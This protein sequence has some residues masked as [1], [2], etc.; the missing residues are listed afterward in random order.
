MKLSPMPI[1][2]RSGLFLFLACALSVYSQNAVTIRIDAARSLGPVGSPWAYVGYDEPNYT[3]SANG[4]KL[5]H[6]L[7]GST[8]APFQFRA[9]NLLTT[10]DATPGLKFGSTDA[11]TENA[12]GLPVYNWKVVDQIFDTYLAAGAK[13]F[14]ELGFMPK[15][16]STHPEPYASVFHNPSDFKDYFRGW[17]YPPTDYRKWGELVYQLVQH[18]VT[19]YGRAEVITWHWEVWNEPDIAYWHGSPADYDKLYDYSA[20]AVKRALPDALV[21]GPAST[22]PRNAK[23]AAFLQQFLE[24]CANGV[25]SASGKTG[26]PLDF[27]T[28]HAK[29]S[30]KVLD[31]HVRMGLSAELNDA[32]AGFKIVRSFAKFQSLPIILSEADPEGCAACSSHDNPANAYRNGALYP[33]YTAIALKELLDL[34]ATTRVSLG[35]ILTWAFEF[36]GQPYFAGY[37]DLATNGIDKPILNYFRMAGLLT[38]ERVKLEATDAKPLTEI[39]ATGVHDRPIIDGLAVRNSHSVSLLVWSYRD[40][41]IAT[42]AANVELSWTNLPSTIHRVLMEQWRVDATQSN[43]YSLWKQLGSPQTLS[44]AQQQELAAAGQLA[45]SESPRWLDCR[46]SQA[47]VSLSLFTPSVSLIKLSW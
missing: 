14:V 31:G 13:P 41:D 21:G 45:S 19:K 6:E 1:L 28:F 12:A 35:G 4:V 7:A 42:P 27:I 37:R 2:P 40:D 36:E 26:A 43:A 17:S 38:G 15:A 20:A 29:G 32:A 39:L 33:A 34:A 46:N 22:S 18:A 47:H 24:H 16:L 10:G 23:A 9:H 44:S 11:Y 3:Y 5:I 8:R 30:P 25:N